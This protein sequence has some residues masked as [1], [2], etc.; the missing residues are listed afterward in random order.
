[1]LKTPRKPPQRM[2][3][4][5]FIEWPGDGT[6]RRSQLIDGEVREIPPGSV[7]RGVIHT[8]VSSLVASHLKA[9]N[10]PY[11]ALIR[12]SIIPRVRASLNLRAPALGVAAA[13]DRPDQY[14]VPDPILL[15]EILTPENTTDVW[16]NVWSYCTIPSL[17]EI[18]VVH[19]TR[20][21]AELL[22]RGCN[23]HWPEEPEEIGPEG[24]LSFASIGLACP[25]LDVYAQTHLGNGD[26]T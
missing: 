5:D 12:P 6:G 20:V 14:V 19:S 25:L 24:M 1:M 22:R 13:P 18:A 3:V 23:G 11:C 16:D 26:T 10:G 21:R 8:N 2:T 9:A 7:A 4:A 17:Q 15:I